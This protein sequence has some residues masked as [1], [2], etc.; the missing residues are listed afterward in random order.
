M[1]IL[2]LFYP[3]NL[4][5]LWKLLQK[6]L[7]KTRSTTELKKIGQIEVVYDNF[8]KLMIERTKGEISL[9]PFPCRELTKKKEKEI[10]Y[11]NDYNGEVEF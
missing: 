7:F 11:P 6:A 5:W 8:N 1:N 10:D 3:A 2:F 9:P 4:K